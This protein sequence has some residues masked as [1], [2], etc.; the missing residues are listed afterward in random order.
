MPSY[1]Y[2]CDSCIT[3]IEVVHGI[4]EKYK[5]LCKKCNSIEDLRRVPSSIALL[6]QKEELGEEFLKN[7]K[8]GE[9]MKQSI[10]ELHEDIKKEKEDLSKRMW[11]PPNP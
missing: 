9:V 6:K 8:P 3:T 5:E 4:D 7:H 1:L 2:I 10:N 11:S